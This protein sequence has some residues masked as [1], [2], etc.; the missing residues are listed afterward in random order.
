MSNTARIPSDILKNYLK[1]DQ[2]AYLPSTMKNYIGRY[3]E[4]S[5][6]LT[7]SVRGDL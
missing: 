7:A 5:N 4:N 3:F 2:L 1:D 6:S